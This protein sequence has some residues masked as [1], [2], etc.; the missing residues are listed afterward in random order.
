[1]IGIIA[2]GVEERLAHVVCGAVEHHRIGVVLDHQFVDGRREPFRA[3]LVA[4]ITQ[5][6][7]QE[8]GNLGR[9]VNE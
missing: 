7:G 9:I 1:M 6:E 5:G 4:A 8:L 3:H 2:H